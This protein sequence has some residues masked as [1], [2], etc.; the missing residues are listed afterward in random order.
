MVLEQ[1]SACD[2][3]LSPARDPPSAPKRPVN[4][5]VRTTIRRDLP[6][7][8]RDNTPVADDHTCVTPLSNLDDEAY[9]L[10][11]SD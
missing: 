7:S 9:N 6:S 2:P 10:P 1:A 8:N 5:Y 3:P 4:P 11:T